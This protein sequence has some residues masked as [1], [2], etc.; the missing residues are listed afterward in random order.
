VCASVT[1]NL[2]LKSKIG[3]RS[4]GKM[5]KAGYGW[6]GGGGGGGGGKNEIGGINMTNMKGPRKRRV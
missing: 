6:G 4:A 1:L 2:T 5:K 3:A